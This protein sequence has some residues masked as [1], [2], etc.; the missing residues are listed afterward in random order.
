MRSTRF[1]YSILIF[2]GLTALALNACAPLAGADPVVPD[3]Y[4]PPTLQVIVTIN[5]EQEASDGKY[6][7]STVTLQF[8]TNEIAG[9][10]FVTFDSNGQEYVK[11][12]G[13]YLNLG[14]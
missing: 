9:N 4:V 10:N 2:V 3:T 12:N 5:E 14:G 13:I 11:C 6:G 7:S 1:R 8:I